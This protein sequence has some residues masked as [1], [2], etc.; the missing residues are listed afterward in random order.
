VAT[1]QGAVVCNP[2]QANT[3]MASWCCPKTHITYEV[4]ICIKVLPKTVQ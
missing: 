4:G 3:K 2:I 1:I